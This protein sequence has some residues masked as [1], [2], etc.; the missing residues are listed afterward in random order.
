M[1]NDTLTGLDREFSDAGAAVPPASN[2]TSSATAPISPA[3]T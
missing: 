1:N 2:W 3:S